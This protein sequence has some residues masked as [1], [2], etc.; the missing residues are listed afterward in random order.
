MAFHPLSLFWDH[1]SWI[2]FSLSPLSP[3]YTFHLFLSS[4]AFSLSYNYSLV[5]LIL[6]KI[7]LRSYLSLKLSSISSY[8]KNILSIY[9]VFN[10]WKHN[11]EQDRQGLCP[12]RKSSL[13]EDMKELPY[14][15]RIFWA[16]RIRNP[17]RYGLNSSHMTGSPKIGSCW[18][19]LPPRTQA[20]SI[21][22]LWHL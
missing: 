20:L 7:S 11:Y 2:I 4:G 5:S 21:F 6:K 12:Y 16:T 8:N 15:L 9:A 18:H 13:D 19:Q 3:L 1:P 22:L 14:Q 10:P 17:T